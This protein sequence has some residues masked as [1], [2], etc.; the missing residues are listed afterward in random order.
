MINIFFYIR[1]TKVKNISCIYYG[2][3]SGTTVLSRKSTGI[4]IPIASWDENRK[5][6]KPYKDY[7]PTNDLLALNSIEEDLLRK[8]IPPKKT[9]TDD[10]DCFIQ[11]F[12]KNLKGNEINVE[13]STKYQVVLNMLKRFVEF[14]YSSKKL[15]ISLM[16]DLDFGYDFKDFAIKPYD[17]KTGSGIHNRKKKP[18]TINNY[19]SVINTFIRKYNEKHQRKNPISYFPKDDN[20]RK[21]EPIPNALFK[22]DIETLERYIPSYHPQKRVNQITNDKLL[23][24]KKVFLFQFYCLGM[25]I[26]DCLLMRT[27]N[28]NSEGIKYL[29]KKTGALQQI[30]PDIN[31]ANQIREIFPEEFESSINSVLLGDLRLNGEDLRD[32]IMTMKYDPKR[33]S[34]MNLKDLK[35]FLNEVKSVEDK[36]ISKHISYLE[37]VLVVMSN[38]VSSKFFQLIGKKKDD[39]IFPFLNIRDFKGVPILSKYELNETHNKLLHRSRVLYNKYLSFIS[40]EL[41]WDRKMTGHTPRHTYANILHEYDA[42]PEEISL[43]LGHKNLTT[44]IKY[45]KRFP[46]NVKTRGIQKFRQINFDRD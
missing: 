31:I 30:P 14:K 25:R 24:A 10:N 35:S 42:H 16:R 34:H 1:D 27:S 12:Q 7:N 28:F 41:R 11:F 6:I 2:I 13:T 8:Y 40:D 15:P 4:K 3:S 45:L 36:G 29:M 22:K 39:F 9:I 26:S 5:T 33:V 23:L 18:Q 43:T 38:Q 20:K 17:G 19:I 21:I 46:S 44:T 32:F 37:E